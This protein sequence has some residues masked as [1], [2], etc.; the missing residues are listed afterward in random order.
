MNPVI[1]AHHHF[2]NY[3]PRE[4]GWINPQ[5]SVLR[6][7]FLPVHLQQEIAPAGV[8]GVISVQAR[9]TVAETDWLLDL[10]DQNDFIRGIVGWAPLASESLDRHLDNWAKRKK[11]LGLRHVL[12]DEPDDQHML[13][14][15][16]DRGIG[17]LK[18]YGLPYDIL[19]FDR[20]LPGAIEM[21][22]RHPDQVFILDHIAK[23]KIAAGEIQ[24]WA[25]RITDLARR[26]NVYCKISG[27][28][29]EANHATWTAA[30]LQPYFDAVLKA[31]GPQ[32]LMFGSDWPVCLLAT[33]YERWIQSVRGWTDCLSAH[34]RRRIMGGTAI[35][36][37]RL[38]K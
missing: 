2:W 30:A 38:Q 7:D 23:P 36:A 24:P 3:T 37:Y 12:Q 26:P 6:R 11:L 25:A 5:M 13:R 9:Q 14:L 32:R 21:V 18:K 10:A 34:E 33:D 29:T 28:A 1:D 35:E 22:D 31:F 4:Y 8:D 27:M 16:F 17:R 20:Q 15:D 19:I